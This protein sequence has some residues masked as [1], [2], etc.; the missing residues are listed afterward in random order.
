MKIIIVSIILALVMLTAGCGNEE[1]SICQQENATLQAELSNSEMALQ[2]AK[3]QYQQEV[4]ELNKKI[5]EIQKSAME[6]IATMLTKQA[7]KDKKIQDVLKAKITEL[8]NSAKVLT[9]ENAN[10][11]ESI[12]EQENKP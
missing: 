10:L 5:N 7:E 11:N 9:E 4:A 8:E 12:T 6:S 1:L 3:K 2:T